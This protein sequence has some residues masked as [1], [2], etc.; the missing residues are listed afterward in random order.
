MHKTSDELE[1]KEIFREVKPLQKGHMNS[2]HSP[3]P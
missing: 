2:L 1:A 3:P